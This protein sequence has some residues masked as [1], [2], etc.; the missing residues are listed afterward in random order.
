M[1]KI[2]CTLALIIAA[3][4]LLYSCSSNK[5]EENTKELKTEKVIRGDLKITV[6]A[7]GVV[8]PYIEVEA[9]SKAGGEIIS[10]PFVEGEKLEKGKVVVRL[11]PQTEQSRVNQANADLLMTEARLEKAKIDLRDTEHR[12]RRQQSLYNDKVISKQDLDSLTIAFEK[13]GSDVKIA[14][15][16]VI[17][18]K[19]TLKEAKDRL[20]DTQ[21]KAPLTGTILKKSVEEGQV[22]ASTISSASEGTLLFTMADLGRIYINAM[23]DETDIGK[24]R[25][26][27]EVSVTADAYQGKVFSGQVLRIAP[28][29]RVEST[30]TVFD[31]IIEVSDKDKSMLRP[32]MSANVEV[33]TKSR[34]DALLVPAESVRTKGDETGVYKLVSSVPQWNRTVIGESNGIRTEITDGVS[35]GDEIVVSGMELNNN[36]RSGG[37]PFFRRH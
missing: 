3:S 23:V 19:E 33:L 15:A 18:S 12:L 4:G 5:A 21:I 24:I 34:N 9:K 22:I 25:P 11:D 31:V 2:I 26:G 10:F 36:K 17:R 7:T 30:I 28:K 32:M 29:G 37:L 1:K 35:E 20:K 13:A 6:A 14:E 8:T 16:D 27:Q